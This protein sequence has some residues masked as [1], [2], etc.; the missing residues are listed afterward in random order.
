MG[1]II[2]LGYKA[3]SGKDSIAEHLEVRHGFRR[4]AFAKSLKE[5]VKAIFHFDD[6][7]VYGELKE[8]HND[9]WDA[10]PRAILQQ[11]GTKAMRDNF[12]NDVWVKSVEAEMFNDLDA[13]WVISDV[14]F[15]NE[16]NMIQLMG[17]SVFRIDRPGVESMIATTSHASETSMDG[18]GGW[19]GVIDNSGTLEDLYAVVD[20]V[21]KLADDLLRL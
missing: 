5:A 10:T 3:R 12:R 6:R 7:H 8:V 2:G 19:D 11:V 1:Q 9:F 16:A 20:D 4:T 13:D 18:W 14:R 21:L 15:P 17:G